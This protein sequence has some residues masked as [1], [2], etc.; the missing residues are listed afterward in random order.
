MSSVAQLKEV[1][2]PERDYA[3]TFLALGDWSELVASLKRAGFAITLDREARLAAL[4]WRL[5]T[6]GVSLEDR[7]DAVDYLAPV[8]CVTADDRLRFKEIVERHYQRREAPSGKP[9]GL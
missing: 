9:E 5:T 7:R 1:T 3:R 2:G 4:L 8:L 6:A